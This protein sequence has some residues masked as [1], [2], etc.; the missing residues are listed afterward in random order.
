MARKRM[1][2]TAVIASAAALGAGLMTTSAAEAAPDPSEIGEFSRPFVEPDI[3]G[4]E[5]ADKCIERRVL[6]PDDTSGTEICKPAAGSAVLLPDGD[7]LYWSALEATE[8]ADIQAVLEFGLVAENDQSRRLSFGPNGPEWSFPAPID[9]G[10]EPQEPLPLIEA[11]PLL[12]DQGEGEVSQILGHDDVDNA[13]GALFGSDQVFL[14]D[15]RVLVASGTDYYSEFGA[16]ELEGLRATRI[17]DP[18]TNSWEDTGDLA[19]GRWYPT[20]VTLPDGRVLA[21][22]GVQKLIKPLYVGEDIAKSGRNETTIESYDPATGEWSVLPTSADR[23]LPLYPRL[24]LLPNGDVFFNT[25]GQTF[26]PFGQAYDEALW[27]LATVFDPDSNTWTDLGVPG[28]QSAAETLQGNAESFPDSVE[29]SQ[30][31]LTDLMDDPTSLNEGGLRDVYGPMMG[32]GDFLDVGYRGSTFGVMLPLRPDESGEYSTVELLSAGGT[33]GPTPGSYAA[34]D[35][36]RLTELTIDGD[37]TEMT[38]RNTAPLNQPRWYGHGT[39]LPTGEVLV[40][41][42][43][44][45]DHVLAPGTESPVT[46]PE[47]FDPETETWTPVAEQI[48]ERTY[49]NSALLLP[50]GRVL[51]GGHNPIPTGYNSHVTL[52]GGF[53]PNDGRDPSF[54]IYSP[55]YLFRGE[56]PSITRVAKTLGQDRPAEV[57]LDIPAS[58][59]D[60]VVLVRNTA[61]THIVD[62]DQRAVEV[63]FRAAGKNRIVVDVPDANVVPAGPYMLFVNKAT[64]EGPIPSKAAMVSVA[65]AN[66]PGNGNGN[67]N[68]NA[69]EVGDGDG[70]ET[71]ALPGLDA[72]PVPGL[73]DEPALPESP[74]EGLDETASVTFDAVSATG[75]VPFGAEGPGR[76]MPLLPA[77]LAVVLIG[78]VIVSG[79]RIRR[80]TT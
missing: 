31:A 76:S 19:N 6:D 57:T 45:R 40:T 71:G 33:M 15:G 14:A 21:F 27:N 65:A 5:T 64:S 48:H 53:A 2:A 70:G 66:G 28:T 39:V 23:S 18:E 72:L 37:S 44:D 61:E 60:D 17:Y 38:S 68:G 63:P 50:D 8:N 41:S 1:R 11:A 59:V 67:G 34:V 69:P 35:F 54:E 30:E 79:V 10:A 16:I 32:E 3:Y 80:T 55:P 25:N 49:H 12:L 7:V 4:Y 46:V 73:P 22:S 29:R 43:G 20:L 78:A 56:Q 75:A 26:N 9:G 47:L 62:G 42:G 13:D 77:S 58:E 74:V 24:H 36:S 52:P 51:V